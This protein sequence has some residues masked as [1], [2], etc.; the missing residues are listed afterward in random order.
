MPV[1]RVET[2]RILYQ[3]ID[4]ARILCGCGHFWTKEVRP[5]SQADIAH[6]TTGWRNPRI[7][8]FTGDRT[9]PYDTTFKHVM[10]LRKYNEKR[11]F[12]DTKF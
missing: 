9:D 1:S 10:F 6:K 7:H 5:P 12:L 4:V 8:S 2:Q 3:F 11:F